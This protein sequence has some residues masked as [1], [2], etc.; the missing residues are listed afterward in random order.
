MLSSRLIIGFSFVFLSFVRIIMPRQ[1]EKDN[2]D[3]M[4][5]I[6]EI[7]LWIFVYDL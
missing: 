1:A 2:A 4:T 6:F 3:D 7:I 5:H